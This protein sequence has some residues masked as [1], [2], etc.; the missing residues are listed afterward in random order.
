MACGHLIQRA[1]ALIRL[2]QFTQEAPSRIFLWWPATMTRKVS[3]SVRLPSQRRRTR[4]IRSPWTATMARVGILF[5][6]TSLF[7]FL[8]WFTTPH[9]EQVKAIH[10]HCR[11]L[12]SRGGYKRA[13][14]VTASSPTFSPTQRLRHTSGLIRVPTLF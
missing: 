3:H 1:A 8:L 6:V 12:V 2:W 13:R 4:C 10:R 11:L 9:S 7:C 5:C 14:A